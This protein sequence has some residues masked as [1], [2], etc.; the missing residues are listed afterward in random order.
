MA[1]KREILGFAITLIL[2]FAVGI[3][4]GRSA[5]APEPEQEIVEKV[6]TREVVR[7]KTVYECPKPSQPKAEKPK[8]KRKTAKKKKKKL[9]TAAPPLTPKARQHLLAWVRDSSADLE[10]CRGDTKETFRLA[11]TLTLDDD[12]KIKHVRLNAP[13]NEIPA[14]VQSCLRKRMKQ[15]TP[16]ADLVKDRSELLFGLTI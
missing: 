1:Q 6:V 10:G 12:H 2:T 13:P 11:V 5:C 14:A 4:L 7:E 16:P 15:W 3:L 9:P 8:G